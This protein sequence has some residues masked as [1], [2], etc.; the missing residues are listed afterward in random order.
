MQIS[1]CLIYYLSVSIC[2][3]I[4]GLHLWFGLVGRQVWLG[5]SKYDTLSYHHPALDTGNSVALTAW[6]F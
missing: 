2:V 3:L 6:T 5:D 1:N 4:L